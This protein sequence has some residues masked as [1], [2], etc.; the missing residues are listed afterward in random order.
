VVF[1]G[2]LDDCDS[3]YVAGEDVFIL[4]FF[5]LIVVCF[6]HK[7]KPLSLHFSFFLVQVASLFVFCFFNIFKF[8]P[9]F[10]SSPKSLCFNFFKSFQIE[11]YCIMKYHFNNFVCSFCLF[12]LPSAPRH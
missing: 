7:I 10:F 9:T 8:Y 3:S 11:L 1:Q 6:H 12:I 2:S 4:A 5:A